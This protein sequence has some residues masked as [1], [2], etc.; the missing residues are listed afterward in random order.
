MIP[1]FNC[2]YKKGPIQYNVLGA[3]ESSGGCSGGRDQGRRPR[4]RGLDANGAGGFP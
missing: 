3:A 2:Y 4:G 1:T